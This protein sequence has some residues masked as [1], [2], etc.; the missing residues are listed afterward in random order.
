MS[1]PEVD[2]RAFVKPNG[3][4]NQVPVY[5]IQVLAGSS[6]SLEAGWSSSWFKI[7]IIAE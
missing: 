7:G 2:N 3:K 5:V 6:A 4:L 1:T